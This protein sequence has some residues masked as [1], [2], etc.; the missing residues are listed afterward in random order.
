MKWFKTEGKPSA[1]CYDLHQGKPCSEATVTIHA[2]LTSRGVFKRW[3]SWASCSVHMLA[4]ARWACSDLWC[5]GTNVRLLNL[6]VVSICNIC[7]RTQE[8]LLRVGTLSPALQISG[9]WGK[10]SAKPSSLIKATVS[11]LLHLGPTQQLRS[12]RHK[13]NRHILCL[14]FCV[15]IVNVCVCVFSK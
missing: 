7:T 5:Q 9:S 8:G 1:V 13:R 2:S 6:L 14:C 4:W 3:H 15:P 11:E 12:I 10:H